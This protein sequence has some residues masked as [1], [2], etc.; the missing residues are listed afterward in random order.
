TRRFTNS[1]DIDEAWAKAQAY[2]SDMWGDETIN[3]EGNYQPPWGYPIVR[4]DSI[5]GCNTLEQAVRAIGFI[6]DD[7]VVEALATTK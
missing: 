6:D 2:L 1:R 7:P 3:D 5:T 4:V